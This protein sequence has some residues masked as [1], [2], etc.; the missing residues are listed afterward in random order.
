[1]YTSAHAISRSSVGAAVAVAQIDRHTALVAVELLE[2]PVEVAG[3]GREAHRHDQ[4]ERIA[5]RPFDLHDVG[6]PFGED[7][8]RRRHEAVFGDL[9]HLHTV[10]HAHAIPLRDPA[11][12]A[13]SCPWFHA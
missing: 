10:H 11:V 9:E 6:A 3:V 1:M 13:S 2:Q 4:A 5:G 12:V 7:R 8:G